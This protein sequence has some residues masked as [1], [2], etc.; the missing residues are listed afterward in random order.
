M[1]N[2][3]LTSKR[4]KAYAERDWGRVI[5]LASKQ[6]ESDPD[7]V[8]ALNDLAVAYHQEG[9]PDEALRTIQRINDL[10]PGKDLFRQSVDLGARYMRYHLVLGEIQFAKGQLDEALKTFDRLKA[11]KGAFSDK[12]F[13]IGQIHAAHGN[14]D[15]AVA[16]YRALWE[17]RPERADKVL[18]AVS[19]LLDRHPVH[20]GANKL[21]FDIC[22]AQGTHTR[23]AQE[24]ET[25]L[26]RSA[27]PVAT[28]RRAYW[29]WFEGQHD[30]ALALLRQY[31]HSQ[32]APEIHWTLAELYVEEG[33][34]DEALR[35]YREVARLGPTKH[36][37]VRDR[38]QRLLSRAQAPGDKTAVQ[39]AL[40]ELSL[41]E[42]NLPA[43]RRNLEALASAIPGQPALMRQL[44]DTLKNATD[45]Y[46]ETGDLDAAKAAL[47]QRLVLDPANQDCRAR[48]QELEG[49]VNERKAQEY[50]SRL[51]TAR[52]SPQELTAVQSE[53]G[54]L[55][56]KQ[57]RSDE[58]A[59]SLYQ[60]LSRSSSPLRA[61]A[62]LTT[63]LIF[64][65]K[66]LV[67]LAER[68][69]EALL[70]AS[71]PPDKQKDCLYQ[72]GLAF[73][74]SKRPDRAREVYERIVGI[75]AAYKD[76]AQRL[77][78]VA[79]QA[80]TTRPAATTLAT[81]ASDGALADRYEQLTEIG[82]GGMGK[83]FRAVDRVL[84]RPV[85]LKFINEDMR[86][87]PEAVSRFIREAQA[88]SAL[89]HPGIVTIYDIQ[90][91]EPLFIAME[92]IDGG[93]LRDRLKQGPMPP[94]EVA[95]KAAAVCDALAYAHRAGVV[96][97]DIKPDNIM[98]AKSGGVKVTDFGLARLTEGTSRV[99]RTGQ[100]L[101]TPAYMAPE[102]IQG[103]VVDA[104][105]DIYAMGVVLY[106]L[107]TGE[108]PFSGGDLA[109]RQVHDRPVPPAVVNPKISQWL[110]AV[111][112][113]ALQK[114][115]EDR[116]QDMTA[117]KR[118]LALPQGL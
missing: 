25:S 19:A 105:T 3:S 48:L 44:E 14:Y 72:I 18:K 70:Q 85:V 71:L 34:I 64:M 116:Y 106:E 117:L 84:K 24:L 82:A 90:V 113:T 21:Q 93:T 33:K 81:P 45:R 101:G 77:E 36:G 65:R 12:Y 111:V 99:T 37:E 27:D 87:D 89:M 75:D 23:V 74:D 98:L 28:C 13:Y 115:P 58:K 32:S 73:E 61:D 29:S 40:F 60:Q 31:A 107:L 50:E 38:L 88:A 56:L 109:Y 59:L 92:Y 110:D 86:S 9:R 16:E 94:E 96:H 35:C 100:V 46:L 66:G 76:V 102:Q 53:L 91:K 43:A 108:L 69:F 20:Q 11:V 7:D 55:Y 30:S 62:Q 68:E 8:K 95:A 42:G 52:L 112:M 6:L 103:K 4:E 17:K 2:L 49:V 78:R 54:S 83:V 104:R 118:D 51:E 10:S 1:F 79:G 39:C 22:R 67:D 63:G 80:A 47:E 15:L 57:G 26:K 114:R 97:R 41:L 5:T